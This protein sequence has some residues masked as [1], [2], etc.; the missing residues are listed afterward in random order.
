M[1]EENKVLRKAV[2]QTMK[3]YYDLQAK[4]SIHQNNHKVLTK[5]RL[6][7]HQSHVIVLTKYRLNFSYGHSTYNS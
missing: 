7:F 5:N 2:E 6:N 1:K 4:F 3:D